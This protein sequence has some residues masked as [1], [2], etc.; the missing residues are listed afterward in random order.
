VEREAY[1]NAVFNLI[2]II[3]TNVD[4]RSARQ[5]T[6]ILCLSGL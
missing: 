5:W 3:R 1:I 6:V 4:L 2:N